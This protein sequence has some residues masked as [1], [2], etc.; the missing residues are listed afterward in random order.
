MNFDNENSFMY[1]IRSKDREPSTDTTN[2]N[3]RLN[4]LPSQYKKYKAT[5]QAI[6][7]S[8][9]LQ[10]AFLEIRS[11][12]GIINNRD[13]THGNSSTI[14]FAT[15]INFMPQSNK[16]EFMFENFNGR[17][18]NFKVYGPDGNVPA[19]NKTDDFVIVLHVV[20]IK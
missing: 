16:F 11:D 3:I 17:S 20:G 14:G 6:L 12:I 19:F 1:I 2:F 18:V 8:A 5:L 10:V 4:G 15:D 9:Q 13:T 7:Y